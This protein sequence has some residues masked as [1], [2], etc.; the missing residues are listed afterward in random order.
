MAKVPSA[1][2][3]GTALAELRQTSKLSAAD[4]VKRL[5]ALG[6]HVVRASIYAYEAGTVA[7]P[8]AGVVWALAQVYGVPV[9]DLIRDLV[10]DRN[11][12]QI[13]QGGKTRREAPRGLSEAE[14]D[15][16]DLWRRLSPQQRKTCDEF[17]RFQARKP[18]ERRPGHKRS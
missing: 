6:I 17:I 8:D 9:A 15:L 1:Q 4:V 7:A 14:I 18:S 11:G 12:G 5:K 10:A 13:V 16:L 2:R 3:W